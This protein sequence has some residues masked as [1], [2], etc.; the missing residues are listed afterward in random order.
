[1]VFTRFVVFMSHF[2]MNYTFITNIYF[3]EKTTEDTHERLGKAKK[4]QK[5]IEYKERTQKY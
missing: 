3:H 1:M 4:C 2:I 5:E